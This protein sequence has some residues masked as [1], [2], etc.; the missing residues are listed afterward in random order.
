VTKKQQK[1]KKKPLP[2]MSLIKKEEKHHKFE[3]KSGL[4]FSDIL[5]KVV[6]IKGGKYG[7]I[8]E[9]GEF[10]I[11]SINKVLCIIFN[12]IILSLNFNFSHLKSLNKAFSSLSSKS[13]NLYKSFNKI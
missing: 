5:V 12:K 4:E 13:K 7:V 10:V 9:G 6:P 8:D 1:T 3:I 11:F 2:K